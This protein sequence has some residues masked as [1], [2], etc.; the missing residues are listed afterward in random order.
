MMVDRLVTTASAMVPIV[1]KNLRR[2]AVIIENVT[3]ETVY[4]GWTLQPAAG[5][6][7]PL[8]PGSEIELRRDNGDPTA[9]IVSNGGAATLHIIEVF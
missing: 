8:A 7:K 1:G 6:G 5:T 3:G 9:A 2:R 4:L